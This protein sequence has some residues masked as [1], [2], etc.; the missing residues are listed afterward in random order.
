MHQ[1]IGIVM[2]PCESSNIKARGYNEGQRILGVEFASGALWQFAGVP[3]GTWERWLEATSAGSFFA[4][5]IRGK[6]AGRK[7]TADCPNCGSKEGPIGTKCVD[8][9]TANYGGTNG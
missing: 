9:G 7:L 3:L 5:H 1:Q 8:C 4:N 2:E 6:F